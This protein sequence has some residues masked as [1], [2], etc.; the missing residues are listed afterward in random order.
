MRFLSRLFGVEILWSLLGMTELGLSGV[1]LT[2]GA[3]WFGLAVVAWEVLQ[4][5]NAE[6]RGYVMVGVVI[7]ALA[8]VSV[9]PLEREL[10]KRTDL[11]GEA[12]W[13]R[14]V[15]VR[16]VQGNDRDLILEFGV[17]SSPLSGV[18]VDILANLVGDN[19]PYWFG[20]SGSTTISADGYGYVGIERNGREHGNF[21]L[22]LQDGVITP[23]QSLYLHLKASKGVSL[24]G[25]LYN[26]IEEDEYRR[27]SESVPMLVCRDGVAI[28][29]GPAAYMIARA[30]PY[31]DSWFYDCR[32]AR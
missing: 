24:R 19:V 9:G 29:T 7:S 22:I 31:P 3:L 13:N 15:R 20:E 14:Y 1:H 10:Y 6:W 32:R 21:G 8:L 25:C 16:Q 2:I 4:E 18:R 28:V 5:A 27:C 17:L 26:L 12:P 30:S 11:Y 23:S